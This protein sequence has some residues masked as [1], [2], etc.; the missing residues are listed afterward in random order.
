MNADRELQVTKAFVSLSTGLA[1]GLDVVDLLSELTE[2][3]VQLLDVASVGLLVADGLGVLH[4]LAASSQA[5]RDLEV[6]QQQR[7]QGPCR[8][9]YHSGT[10][11]SVPDLAAETPRWPLFAPRAVSAGFLSVH[12][13]PL[14]LRENTLGAMNLFGTTVG[15]LDPR[16]LVLA[17]A[18]ADVASV[19]LIQDQTAAD[20]GAVVDQLQIALNS[21]VVLEQAKG[22]VAHAGELDMGQAFQVLRRYARDHNLRLTAVAESVVNLNVTTQMLLAHAPLQRVDQA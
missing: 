2:H 16:D 7:D 11:V 17:Q 14:R 10:P 12:A 5:T 9:C 6:F 22:V 8:D 20:R 4:V 18:L 21:R 13:V 1:H 15:S 19:A 3:C